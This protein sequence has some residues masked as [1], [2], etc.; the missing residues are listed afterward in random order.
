[1]DSGV[2]ADWEITTYYD[3]M[4]SKI[5]AHAPDRAAATSRMLEA[6]DG[7]TITGLTTNL[8]MHKD[9][10]RDEAFVAADFHTKWL[11]KR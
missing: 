4:I 9:V 1:M 6:L 11:E 7:Y 3:P 2:Q 5:C 8:E 10:L